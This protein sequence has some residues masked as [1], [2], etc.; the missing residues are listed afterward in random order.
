MLK[1]VFLCAFLGV[2]FAAPQYYTRPEQ[3]AAI[4]RLD[5]DSYPDGSYNYNYE[6]QN[7]IAAQEQG[8]P[9]PV[10]ND[11]PVVVQGTY[12]YTSP[13]GT[14][15][16]VNYVADENG[17]RPVGNV[18]SPGVQRTAEQAARNAAVVNPYNPYNPYRNY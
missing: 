5:S 16:Q 9:K 15:V 4:L 12:Q 3:V 8:Q 18:I 7:G 1:L 10:G 11:A 14:P 13:D 6:T 2:C 17:F